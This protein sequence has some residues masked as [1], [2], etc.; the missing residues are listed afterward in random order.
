MDCPPYEGSGWY[1]QNGYIAPA[2]KAVYE[3][4]SYEE[5]REWLAE[6]ASED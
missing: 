2:E 1:S 6:H 4:L 3:F 5:Y